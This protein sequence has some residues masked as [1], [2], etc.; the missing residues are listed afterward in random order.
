M[1]PLHGALITA[2]IFNQGRLIE[3]TIV[4]RIMDEDTFML[5]DDAGEVEIYL[6]PN[7]VP[8]AVG[9]TVTV[10]GIVD[11]DEG[12]IPEI[13]AQSLVTETGET[14]TFDHSYD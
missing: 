1:S 5:R 12:T 7:P 6:G 13:Y 4:D 2:T 3:P 10:S 14:I 11:D 8:V 9:T